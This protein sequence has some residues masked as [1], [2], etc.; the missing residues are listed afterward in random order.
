MVIIYNEFGTLIQYVFRCPL[1]VDMT[2][3]LGVDFAGPDNV[4]HPNHHALSNICVRPIQGPDCE[5]S[6][7]D[8]RAG[9]WNRIKFHIRQMCCVP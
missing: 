3:E 1:P 7:L 9:G 5:V 6:M 4:I 8:W 2:R